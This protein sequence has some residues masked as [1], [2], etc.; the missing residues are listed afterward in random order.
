MSED[1]C[2]YLDVV[3]PCSG[4]QYT[5]EQKISAAIQYISIGNTTRLAQMIGMPQRTLEDWTKKEWW[6]E[7]TTRIREEKKPE[8]DAMFSRIIE[9]SAQVIETELKKG[10]VKARDAATIMG[11]SFDKKQVLNNQPTS[12]SSSIGSKELDALREL[13]EAQ[14]G[15]TIEGTKV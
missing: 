1:S 12:I 9:T 7:L 10:K 14:A 13:F 5:H 11:I 6:R 4:S 3:I 2:T 15:R 8:Y